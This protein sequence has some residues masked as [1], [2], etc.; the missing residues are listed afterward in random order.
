MTTKSDKFVSWKEFYLS[1]NEGNHNIIAYNNAMHHSNSKKEILQNLVQEVDSV[2]LLAGED[3]QMTVV[4]SPKNFGGTRSRPTDKLVALKGMGKEATC[5]VLD[6][7]LLLRESKY[8]VPPQSKQEDILNFCGMKSELPAPF[9][10]NHW[11]T[12]DLGHLFPP[13]SSE[14]SYWCWICIAN[15]TLSH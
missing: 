11:I 9:L 14:M 13:L 6:E 2:I 10:V 8:R 4:H 12:L 3:Q 7:E 5:I 15:T 1:Q